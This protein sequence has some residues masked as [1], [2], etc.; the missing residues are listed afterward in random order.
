MKPELLP[1]GERI[2]LPLS[3]VRGDLYLLLKSAEDVRK[4]RAEFPIDE[5]TG[6]LVNVDAYLDRLVSEV[7]VDE[8]GDAFGGPTSTCVGCSRPATPKCGHRSSRS[9]TTT[10]K[11]T[12]RPGALRRRPL[13]SAG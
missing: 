3:F 1:L 6:L 12:Q 9:T 7:V 13:P 5:E 2:P 10:Q 4:I 8:D 11:K